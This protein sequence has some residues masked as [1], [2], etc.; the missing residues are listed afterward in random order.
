M[1]LV[2][3]AIILVIVA[4]VGLFVVWKT[5]PDLI[6]STLSKKMQVAVKIGDIGV[7][8]NEVKVEKLEIANPAG[9]TL[10]KAF[11]VETIKVSA[12]LTNYVKDAIVIDEITLDNVYLSLELASKNGIS[13]N[14]G[15]IMDNI[16]KSSP[17][18]KKEEPT[19]K[20]SSVLIKKLVL[21]NLNVDLVSLLTGGAVKKLDPIARLEF[22]NISSDSGVPLV[23]VIELILGTV[24]KQQNMGGI[25]KQ[26]IMTP[27]SV[28]DT[29]TTPF[30]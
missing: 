16:K 15:K 2:R 30:K 26:A 27:K 23:Q 6:A 25:L 19:K 4:A 5:A 18:E 8:T 24:L 11:S 9:S 10:P 29:L 20:G 22:D 17:P 12:P 3:I 1:K 28:L 21:T 14:W 13:G 7:S